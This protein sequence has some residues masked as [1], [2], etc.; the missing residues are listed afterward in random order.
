[1]VRESHGQRKNRIWKSGQQ[2]FPMVWRWRLR[3]IE[4][5]DVTQVFDLG[6]WVSSGTISSN[7]GI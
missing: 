4:G 7:E 3:E 1:M 5:S 6:C 2:D